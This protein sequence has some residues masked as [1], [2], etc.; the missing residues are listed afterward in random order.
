MLPTDSHSRAALLARIRSWTLA[1]KGM[2]ILVAVALVSG[3]Y[4]TVMAEGTTSG[5]NYVLG[6]VSTGDVVMTVSGSGQIAASNDVDVEAKG[7]GALTS[8]DVKVGDT[9]SAG[10]QIASIDPGDAG[11]QLKE[12]QLSYNE[13]LASKSTANVKSTD[14]VTQGQAAVASAYASARSTVLTTRSSLNSS[15]V[16]LQNML[17]DGGYLSSADTSAFASTQR[18][19]TVATAQ[20]AASD[21]MAFEKASQGITAADGQASIRAIMDTGITA[22]TSLATAAQAAETTLEYLRQQTNNLNTSSDATNAYSSASSILSAAT[23]ALSSLQ[24]AE[25][26]ITDSQTSLSETQASAVNATSQ[27][28]DVLSAQL[29]VQEKQQAYSDFFVT[30]P[31]TGIVAKIDVQLGD[32][33]NSGSTVATVLTKDKVANITLNEVDATNVHVGDKA[34]LT[35]D[36]I[37]GLTLTGTV[38]EIDLVGTVTQGVVSYG[39]KITLDADDPRVAS[40]MTVNADIITDSAQDVL[41]VPASAIS[42]TNGASYVKVVPSAPAAAGTLAT[43]ST[44]AGIARAAAPGLAG[45]A[46]VSSADV[47]PQMVEVTT[48]LTDGS[49]TQITS[50]LSEGQAIVLRTQSAAAVKTTAAAAT[51]RTT[52]AAGAVRASGFGG[53]ATV[54]RAKGG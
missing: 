32:N 40:G 15:L 3:V 7:S 19:A 16:T 11:L 26:G 23:S 13:L 2:S 37:D 41:V 4:G 51:T 14:S 42:T 53:G 45:G 20:Q 29:N 44:T 9:V 28:S 52:G 35:F 34:T 50:G 38:E 21:V 48:G 6:T 8:L 39:A 30:A 47:T 18:S 31:F 27:S 49:N 12:A 25:Q 17:A 36:A 24:S 5:T 1:H 46:I 54:F 22:A 10:Q 33:V 43:A